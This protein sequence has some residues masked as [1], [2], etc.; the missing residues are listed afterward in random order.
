MRILALVAMFLFLVPTA[1]IAEDGDEKKGAQPA[2]PPGGGGGRGRGGGGM[3]DRVKRMD[4]NGDG[5]ITRDEFT[6]PE[7]M[8][9][10]LDGDGN[11]TITTKEI[12]SMASRRGSGGGRG[13]PG[14]SSRRG[15]A[16]LTPDQLDGDKDQLVSKKELDAW[17]AKADRNGDGFVDQAEWTAAVSGRALHDP[18][19]KVGSEAPKVSAKSLATKQL[20]DL[21]DVKRTTVLIFGSH[22]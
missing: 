14:G 13:A 10:R 17:F 21:H 12:E 5:E 9:D 4:A 16:G 7:R 18:A 11:G 1:A 19:P 15:P 8:W 2:P 6:G 3:L 20:V 22:T